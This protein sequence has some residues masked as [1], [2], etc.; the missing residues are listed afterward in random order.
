MHAVDDDADVV[1]KNFAQS[2]V[3]L[4]SRYFASQMRL[5]LTLDHRERALNITAF[6][7]MSF[8]PVRA[9]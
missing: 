2:F 3:L 5:K 9:P 1:A 6:V 7:I 4:G 8:K